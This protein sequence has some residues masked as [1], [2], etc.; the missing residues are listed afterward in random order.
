MYA[1]YYLQ[2]ILYFLKDIK[3]ALC[4][5]IYFLIYYRLRILKKYDTYFHF[6]NNYLRYTF[7]KFFAIKTA[8]TS[9][10]DLFSRHLYAYSNLH[11]ERP[12]CSF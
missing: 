12:L 9:F 4:L 3:L 6:F 2:Q 10:C 7:R 8:E 11:T 1:N 5:N